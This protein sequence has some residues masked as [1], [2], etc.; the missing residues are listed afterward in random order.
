[1][2]L[3]QQIKHSLKFASSPLNAVYLI[4]WGS[5][6]LGYWRGINNHIPILGGITDELEFII[7]IVPI[8]LSLPIIVK[9]ITSPYFIFIFCVLIVYF[10]NWAFFPENEEELTKRSVTFF[11]LVLPYFLVGGT[12]DLKKFLEPFYVISVIVIYVAT[13]YSLIYAQSELYAGDVKT[14]DYN[15]NQAY[16]VLPHVL[17]VTWQALKKFDIFKSISMIV[18]IGL[19]LSYGTRGPLLCLISFIAIYLLFFKKVN[20]QSVLLTMI[21]VIGYFVIEYLTP[22]MMFCQT[23]FHNLGMSTRIFDYY[24]E[25]EIARSNGRDDIADTLIHEMTTNDK[26]FGH[27]LL[28][29][30]RYVNT[31]PHNIGIEFWFSFGYIW[32]SLLLISIIGLISFSLWK[33]RKA[34]YGVFIILLFCSSIIKLFVTGTFLD[35]AMFF[36]LIGYCFQLL[37]KHKQ[38]DESPHGLTINPDCQK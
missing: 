27:G 24:F 14:T 37:S 7:V 21:I 25:N 26:L 2:T 12:L 19:V 3:F 23:L 1:M 6:L 16:A 4:A 10:A 8:L 9:K 11:F 15:M 17:L 20:H 32:G 31:Y 18:G 36:M 5:I 33:F 28:G 38:T 22:I 29:Y 34:D 30:Y 13:F 35:D